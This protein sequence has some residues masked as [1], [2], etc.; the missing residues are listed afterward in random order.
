[1]RMV[2]VPL[3]ALLCSSC[4]TFNLVTDPVKQCQADT[5]GLVAWH[6]QQADKEAL[7]KPPNGWLTQPY[8]RENWDLYWNDVVFH[9]G[10]VSPAHCSGTYRGPMGPEMVRALLAYRRSLGLP[11]VNFEEL[12]ASTGP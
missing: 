4:S 6:Q 2:L 12:N 5:A 8:S 3:V 9:V 11:E 1:M 7:G 10:S